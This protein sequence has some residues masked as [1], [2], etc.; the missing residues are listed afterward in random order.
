[1][2]VQ[3]ITQAS[4]GMQRG[5]ARP[6]RGIIDQGSLACKVTDKK[7]TTSLRKYRKHNIKVGLVGFESSEMT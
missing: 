4:W 1:M 5:R 6:G 7:N 2:W 3:A